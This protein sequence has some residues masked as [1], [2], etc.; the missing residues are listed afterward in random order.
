MIRLFKGGFSVDEIK[1]VEEFL[2]SHIFLDT[3]DEA[4]NKL[5]EYCRNRNFSIFIKD[6]SKIE[7][8]KIKKEKND[9]IEDH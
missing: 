9:R 1:G 5:D 7:L 6:E 3:L 8:V 4:Q 2:N